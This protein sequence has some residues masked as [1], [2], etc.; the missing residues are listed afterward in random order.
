MRELESDIALK[1]ELERR[2]YSVELRQLLALKKLSLFTWRKP[3]VLVTSALYD[4]ETVNSFA[5]NNVGRIDKIVNLHWEQILSRDQENDPFFSGRDAAREAVHICWGKRAKERLMRHGLPEARARV[6]GPIHFDFLRPEFAPYHLSRDQLAERFGLDPAKRWLLLISSYSC[7]F[8]N[9]DELR[10]MEGVTGFPYGQ[11]RDVSLSA[12]RE[13]LRWVDAMLTAGRPDI[14]FIYRPHPN[15]WDS[16]LLREMQAKHPNFRV[17]G[18]LPI[19]QW[20]LTADLLYTWMSTAIPE[21]Y[22][23]G[24]S[25]FVL[26]PDKIPELF[27]PVIYSGVRAVDNERDFIASADELHPPFPIDEAELRSHYDVDPAK[28]CAARVCDLLEEVLKAPPAGR[29]MA[30]FRPRF[31]WLKALS[32]IPLRAMWRLRIDPKWFAPSWFPALRP[33]AEYAARII[34]YIDKD[35]V[36]KKEIAALQ[37]KIEGVMRHG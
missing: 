4:N 20:I 10:Y 27:D 9:E 19:R 7:A 30:Q 36:P 21:I 13:T 34:G 6:T 31:S 33:L 5:Y 11:F 8:M 37:R 26:R 2:G 24:R 35:A 25:C 15:E 12:M 23:A 16:P 29:P 17:I 14:E 22:F 18:D 28:T 1:A 32:L 3:K